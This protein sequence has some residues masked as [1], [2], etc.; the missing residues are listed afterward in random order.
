MAPPGPPATA[1]SVSVAI[2]GPGLLAEGERRTHSGWRSR[3]TPFV[4][5]AND[6]GYLRSMSEPHVTLDPDSLGPVGR[7]LRE[8]LEEQLSSALQAAAHRVKEGTP[9]S[10]ST[11]SRR[12]C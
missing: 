9:G 5:L 1:P 10:R 4:W 3:L 11:T 8:P 6:S 7:K 12:G 2:T